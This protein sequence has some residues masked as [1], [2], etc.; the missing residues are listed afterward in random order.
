MVTKRFLLDEFPEVMWIK[1]EA[2]R[3]KCLDT[4]ADALQAGGWDEENASACPIAVTELSPECPLGNFS[5]VH[6]VM[7]LCKVMCDWY[8]P[9]YAEH[10]DCDPDMVL[11][12]A[13][14][15]D[16][17]K[18]TEY[19]IKDGRPAYA[20]DARYMRHPLAGAILAAKHG[21]PPKVV[22]A[23]ATH[24]FE[25][26]ASYQSP[27]SHLLKQADSASFGYPHLRFHA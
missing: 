9:R 4:F 3:E 7:Y 19:T 21:L 1:D 22:H 13:F 17:C 27:E 11:A 25:G 6:D 2:L 15:H 26:S 14:L 18:Y 5:H 24:S 16:C 20:E 23:I 8:I 10:I 12:A